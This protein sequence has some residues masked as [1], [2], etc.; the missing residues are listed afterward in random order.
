MP[1][2][3]VSVMGEKHDENARSGHETHACVQDARCLMGADDV[4]AALD[5]PPTARVDRRVPKT[6]LVEHGAPTAADKRRINEGIEEVQWVATLKPTTIGV[7]ALRDEVREY[8]EIV[9]L[10]VALRAE[11]KAERLSELIHRAVPYPVFLLVAEGTGLTLSLAHK[12]R[13]QGEAGATVLDGE[14]VAVAV[15]KA[16]AGRPH[17]SFREA[18][19][20]ARQPRADL[21][22]LY[23]GWIDTLLALLAAEVTGRFAMAT[24]ADHASA[25]REA[26]GE[27]ARCDAEITRLRSV[28]AT[29]KQVARQVELNLQ[30][31]RAEAA[32]AAALARL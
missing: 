27:C 20:L 11:A 16:D 31:K 1:G 25:R 30:I 17:S 4:I 21:F 29:E 28:A 22:Q 15:T 10:S 19:S 14:P 32:R 12:R 3:G 9:V 8:L 24:S 23:Q 2:G 5:L 18:L 6:L 26:L 13:S 7:P